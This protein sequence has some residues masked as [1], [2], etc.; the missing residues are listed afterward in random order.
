M[1]NFYVCFV[2]MSWVGLMGGSSYVNVM[3]SILE[4]PKL[5]KSEKELAMTMTGVCNDLGILMASLM[6]LLLANTAFKT[7]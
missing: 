1:E 6:S 4:S 7:N 5:A 3:Y 2:F